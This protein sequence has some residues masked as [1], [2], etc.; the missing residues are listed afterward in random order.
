MKTTKFW[1]LPPQ[2]KDTERYPL[3]AAEIVLIG[4]VPCDQNTEWPEIPCKL[5]QKGLLA[6]HNQNKFIYETNKAFVMGAY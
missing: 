4:V 2:L 3:H 1:K 6:I 5:I